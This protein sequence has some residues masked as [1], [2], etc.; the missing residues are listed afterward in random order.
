MVPI[1]KVSIYY[2]FVFIVELPA[3]EFPLT[4]FT[5][6]YLTPLTTTTLL[7]LSVTGT[8]AYPFTLITVL[9]SDFFV[10][11]TGLL[12]NIGL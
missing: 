1:L 2:P 6:I 10:T 4:Y 9:V 7:S 3:I 5:G 11:L 12:R 8:Y